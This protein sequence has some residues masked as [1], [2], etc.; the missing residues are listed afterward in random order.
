MSRVVLEN[1][2][3]TLGQE[4]LRT[5]H[6]VRLVSRDEEGVG[7]DKLPGGVY[8][9][10]YSPGL[11]NAPLFAERRHR[12]FEIH[13]FE[14]GEVSVTGFASADVARLIASATEDVT[15]Q[16]QPHPEEGG[17]TLVEIPVSRIRNHKGY[18][19][20]NQLGFTATLRPTVV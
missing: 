18:S 9:Y 1:T 4:S 5:A 17:D 16:V 19:A 2:P 13:K 15:I 11:P 10:S 20:P 7:V 8:G 6:A 14:S 3:A 12:A